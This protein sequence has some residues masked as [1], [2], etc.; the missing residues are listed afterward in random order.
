MRVRLEALRCVGSSEETSYLP[1]L[2]CCVT[3]A[4]AKLETCEKRASLAGVAEWLNQEVTF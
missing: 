2:R 3:V 4:S 1:P